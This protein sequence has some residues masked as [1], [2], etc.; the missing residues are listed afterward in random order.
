MSKELLEKL[1][2]GLGVVVVISAAL[3]WAKQVGDVI[4]LLSMAYGG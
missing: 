1:T 4:E 3:F 2:M